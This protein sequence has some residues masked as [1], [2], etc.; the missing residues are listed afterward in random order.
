[1]TVNREL[2]R[3]IVVSGPSGAG[4]GSIVLRY[5]ERNP[6]CVLSVSAT[7]R[8]PRNGEKDTIHYHFIEAEM[9]IHLLESGGM[10]EHTMYNGH[11]YGTPRSYVEEA[12]NQG[13]DVILEIEV[14]GGMQVKANYP[15]A[16]MI[17]VLPPS[18]P[19]LLQRLKKRGSE[20]E[21]AICGRLL[22]AR[23]ELAKAWNY[24]YILINDD[25]D[26]A[27]EDF[28][29]IIKAERCRR[30]NNPQF[31]REFSRELAAGNPA[32]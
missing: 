17:F 4:K 9:F 24:D 2:G 25:L 21:E 3:L 22:T 11:Y 5:M 6:D 26:D 28:R 19:V 30:E 13:Q 1:M 16:V 18:Y 15:D 31:L 20:D 27:V 32:K 23:D 10:L 29:S 7:T 8:P 14:N 12:I